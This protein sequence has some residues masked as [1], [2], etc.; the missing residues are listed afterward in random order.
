MENG[1]GDLRS[2]SSSRIQRF[3]LFWISRTFQMMWRKVFTK[4]FIIIDFALGQ[5]KLACVWSD[6]KKIPF[7]SIHLRTKVIESRNDSE[8]PHDSE[9][10][11]EQAGVDTLFSDS[12][13][14]AFWQVCEIPLALHMP[15]QKFGLL[16]CAVPNLFMLFPV[17]SKLGVGSI[18][19]PKLLIYL[20]IHSF[21]QWISMKHYL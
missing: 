3:L 1:R 21:A 17:P 5:A 6:R 9:R 14:L 4:E 10:P 18:I 16:L 7:L 12:Y 13:L 15:H 19:L 2:F 8:V 11:T 20:H